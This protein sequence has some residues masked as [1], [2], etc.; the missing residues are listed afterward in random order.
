MVLSNGT[1]NLDLFRVW[2]SNEVLQHIISI[3]LPHSNFK[4]DRVIWASLAFGSFFVRGAYWSLKQD[5]WDS[6][7]PLWK[8]IWRFQGHQRVWFFLWL[9]YKQT[10]LTNHERTRHGLCH[11][12]FC[13]IYGY[14][15][16]DTLHALCDCMTAKEVWKLVVPN[17]QQN[18]FFSNSFQDWI[19]TNLNC[20]ICLQEH[21]VN[22][23][24]LFGIIAW[25]I[26][27]NK[28]LY[29]LQNISWP[30][31]EII[32][33]SLSWAW[34]F[35]ENRPSSKSN[36]ISPI[37]KNFPEERWVLLTSDGVVERNIGQISAN[38]VIRDSNGKWILGFNHYLGNCPPFEAEL[39]EVLDGVLVLLE[40][41]FKRA[42][43]QIANLEVVTVLSE[44]Y[45]KDISIM[46]LRR[47]QRLI[48]S[49]GQWQIRYVPIKITY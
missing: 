18:W 14:V 15:N 45:L 5:S 27:K 7:N 38:G 21:G 22:W 12:S 48:R 4:V 20:L 13:A 47:V 35:E 40:K 23:A 39:W 28:N 42:I 29:I 44:E 36:T 37:V 25:R 49:E 26:W 43:I 41:G 46:I 3:P 8:N 9:V 10:L 2:L 30:H 6:M 31:M 16:E 34:Q 17:D 24:S 11:S 1:W 33:A 32:K 19:S